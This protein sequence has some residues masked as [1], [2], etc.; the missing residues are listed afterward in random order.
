MKTG[1]AQA[2]GYENE[3]KNRA[4]FGLVFAGKQKIDSRVPGSGPIGKT[5]RYVVDREI[6]ATRD[7]LEVVELSRWRVGIQRFREGSLGRCR[8]VSDCGGH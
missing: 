1:V 7:V 5:Q 4:G 6:E 2:C 3:G 8:A